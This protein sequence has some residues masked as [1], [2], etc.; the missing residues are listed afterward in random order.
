MDVD[1]VEEGAADAFLVAGDGGGGAAAL[2][3]GGGVEAPEVGARV[4]FCQV[5]PGMY[6]Y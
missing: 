4:C 1:A 3:D 2:F 6:G 5:G